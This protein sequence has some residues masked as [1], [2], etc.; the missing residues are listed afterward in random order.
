MEGS[1]GSRR[2]RLPATIILL[3]SALFCGLWYYIT[4][5][6]ESMQAPS[7]TYSQ[8]R[9]KTENTEPS[10]PFHWRMGCLQ[11]KHNYIDIID[12]SIISMG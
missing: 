1:L 8:K 2:I 12:V 4:C 7:H 5:R 6:L 3:D 11:A 10:F 9:K